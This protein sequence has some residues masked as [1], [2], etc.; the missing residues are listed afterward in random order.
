MEM[1]E[2]Y[3]NK[4]YPFIS[5]YTSLNY[6][7]NNKIVVDLIDEFDNM[8]SKFKSNSFLIDRFPKKIESS[9]FFEW[10]DVYFSAEKSFNEN[11]KYL[12]VETVF[13]KVIDILS[14][15]STVWLET[16]YC[17]NP[18]DVPTE[19][20]TENDKKLLA[21]IKEQDVFQVKSY[22]L[23]NLVLKL[24]FRG[25][26]NTVIYL[27]DLEAILA[28]NDLLIQVISFKDTSFFDVICRTEGLYFR[29]L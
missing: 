12:E 6:L 3:L 4:K 19:I 27:P 10:F 7:S 2:S 8:Q 25:Y 26:I 24:S 23:Y 17:F 14:M 22:D 13:L 20:L 28:V 15:Y 16:S 9:L 21:S 11:K 1:E 18:E 29:Q 5:A